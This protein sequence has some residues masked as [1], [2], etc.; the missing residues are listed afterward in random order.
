MHFQIHSLSYPYDWFIVANSANPGEMVTSHLCLRCL[1]STLI[2]DFQ[3]L[4]IAMNYQ[5]TYLICI[6]SHMRLHISSKF[7]IAIAKFTSYMHNN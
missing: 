1:S 3:N 2:K 4:K 7:K 6:L 5:K